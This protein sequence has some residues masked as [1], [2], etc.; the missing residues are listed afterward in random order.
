MRSRVIIRDVK[1]RQSG[2]ARLL[3]SRLQPI[4]KDGLSPTTRRLIKRS[5]SF[6]SPRL[7]E[8]QVCLSRN[9]A[10][11]D[12]RPTADGRY[13][14]SQP[15]CFKPP[16]PVPGH[17]IAVLAGDTKAQRWG[18]WECCGCCGKLAFA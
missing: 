11:R 18:F 5:D 1:T 6:P 3:P 7:P 16:Q 2:V 8:T 12:S 15:P 13:L 4:I 10:G 9:P 17:A 14:A